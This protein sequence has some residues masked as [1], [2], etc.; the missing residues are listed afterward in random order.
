MIKKL[1]VRFIRIVMEAFFVVLVVI[2]LGVNLVNR[3]N[4]YSRIDARLAFL[5]ESQMG[6]PIGMVASTP[7][8]IRNWVDMNS[9]GIMNETSYFILTGNMMGPILEHQLDMLTVASGYDARTLLEGL[10]AGN[11]DAGTVGPYRYL[12]ATRDTPYRI[13]F[14]NCE[15]EFAALRSLRRTTVLVGIASFLLV[16]ALV[17]LLSEKAM[18]PFAQNI[19]SQRRFISNASHELKTPL[20]VIVSDLDIQMLETGRT[21]WL[22]SA[23]EQADH[24]ALLIDQLTTYSLLDEKK[25]NAADLPVDLSLLAENAVADFRPKALMNGQTITADIR[26]EITVTG[27]EDALRTLFSVLMDN[28]VK[29]TPEGGSIR[30]SL[31]R[32]KKAEI[33]LKNTVPP[34][35]ELHPERLF[36]RFYRA[37]EHRAAQ[38][39]HGLGLA[40]AHEIVTMYGGSIRATTVGDTVT[41]LAEL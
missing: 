32:E 12:V 41:F 25:Q 26:P 24:L 37:P 34:E 20:G 30:L 2:L 3:Q 39:G 28:A 13:V 23:Q 18:Q 17:T 38:D 40:I 15:T 14:V 22:E 8:E 9:A 29:Y 6:P 11:S 7:Q 33:E 16:F 5:A 19:E 21:E 36:E 10:L 31:R 35:T 27:N 1:R 4:V